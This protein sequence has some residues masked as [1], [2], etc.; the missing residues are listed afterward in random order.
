MCFFGQS[1]D[2]RLFILYDKVLHFCFNLIFY[3]GTFFSKKEFTSTKSQF[4][5]D[6]RYLTRVLKKMFF[7][8]CDAIS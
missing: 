7:F 1:S 8:F 3:A 2:Y 4:F 6:S 5:I